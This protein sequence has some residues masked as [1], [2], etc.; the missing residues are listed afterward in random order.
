M[1][2]LPAVIVIV[3]LQVA[4][5]L[6][7]HPTLADPSI[8][9]IPP[10]MATPATQLPPTFPVTIYSEQAPEIPAPPDS[11]LVQAMPISAGVG[12]V[13]PTTMLTGSPYRNSAWRSEIGVLLAGSLNLAGD[14]ENWPQNAQGIRF[15]A[16]YE[17]GN[18]LGVRFRLAV[19]G[20][21]GTF[22]SGD[23]FEATLDTWSVDFYKRLFLEDTEVVLG[24]G[25][26][27]S[28]ITFKNGDAQSDFM[29]GGA[30]A[31]TELWHPF[32]RHG[33]TDYGLAA[34]GRL[35][36]SP[37]N[38]TRADNAPI[39][40]GRT[41]H[42]TLTIPEIAYGLEI[43]RRFGQYEDKYFYL[44]ALADYQTFTSPWMTVWTGTSASICGLNL[45][46]GIAY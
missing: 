11:V 42:D 44:M 3:L 43:R 19:G 37:G 30:T 15:S 34:R 5:A 29:G 17:S 24:G 22:N 33:R 27:G 8:A 20:N 39:L 38:W 14:F 7:Q 13:A 1:P 9:A 21:A 41:K 12:A 36:I 35:T 6:A 28:G 26:G 10:P 31:F 45:I 32:Y 40:V 23:H 25:G 4:C 18:G 2:K 16:G 46:A